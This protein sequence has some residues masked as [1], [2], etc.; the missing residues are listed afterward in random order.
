MVHRLK[1]E[2]TYMSEIICAEQVFDETEGY[3]DDEIPPGQGQE[4]EKVNWLKAGF[5]SADKLLTVSPN[6][7]EE[8]ASDPQ[9]G[10]E[11]DDVIR[12]G[13]AASSEGRLMCHFLCLSSACIAEGP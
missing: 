12:C 9:K 3:E 8:I 7:A 11:L 6:Y 5:L 4:Y 13:R 1:F 10:V 2:T